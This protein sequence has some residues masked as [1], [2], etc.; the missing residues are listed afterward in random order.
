MSVETK[1]DFIIVGQGL[2]GSV[3]ALE[4]VK[5]KKNII[6]FDEPE[7]NRASLIAAGLFNP[8]TGK[9]MTRTWKAAELFSALRFFYSE[10]EQVIKKKCFY[11]MP[12]YRPFL[13]V[14]EQNEWMG[15]SAESGMLDHIEK[16]F[17]HSTYGSDVNDYFG[18][19]LLKNCGYLDTT[20][21]LSGVRQMLIESN[22]FKDVYFDETKVGW[23]DREVRYEGIRADK[24]IYANGLGAQQSIFFNQL[25]LRALKGETLLIKTASTFE[26]IYNRGVYLVPVGEKGVYKVGATY[27]TKDKTGAAT[28]EG[29]SELVEKLNGLIK[30]SYDIIGQDWGFRPTTPDRRPV[31]G[32]HP[33]HPNLVIFNGLGTK[34]VSLAPYFASQMAQ[35]LCGEGEIEK[36]VRV[37]RFY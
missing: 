1:V 31:L 34:G 3:L 32:A 17:A 33:D 24:I 4:L 29:K 9:L 6:V 5:R 11:P 16:V 20:A 8:V 28:A 26:R 7:K 14:E 18:G 30:V 35:W 10:A 36:A 13:S 15:K 21:F 2:A 22:C 37:S 23:S 25:P 27:N 12:L 19:L